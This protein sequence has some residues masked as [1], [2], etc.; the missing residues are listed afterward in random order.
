MMKTPFEQVTN[1]LT[2]TVYGDDVTT[3]LIAGLMARV[4]PLRICVLT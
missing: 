2:G 4:G 1:S 3:N